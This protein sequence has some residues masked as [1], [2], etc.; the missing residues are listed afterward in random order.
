MV[1][2]A[3]LV[4]VSLL[5]TDDG[6]TEGFGLLA[7][8]AKTLDELL[9]SQTLGQLAVVCELA[10]VLEATHAALLAEQTLGR[11][12]DAEGVVL[13]AVHVREAAVKLRHVKLARGVDGGLGRADGL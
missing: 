5:T 6:A 12:I 10:V 3:I 13:L 9:L 1:L 7:G 8:K 11:V 4:L 2:E